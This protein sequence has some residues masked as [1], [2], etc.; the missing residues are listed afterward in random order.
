ME[1]IFTKHAETKLKQR[2]IFKNLAIETLL[3]PDFIQPSHGNREAAFRK[4]GR[5]YL[6]VIFR[7]EINTYVVITQHWIAKLKK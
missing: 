5:K 1:I 4:V 6:K 3:A 7:R 2:R